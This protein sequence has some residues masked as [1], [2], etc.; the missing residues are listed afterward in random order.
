LIRGLEI[1]HESRAR[2]IEIR[3]DSELVLRQVT[4]EYKCVTESLVMYHTMANALLR[5]FT[6]VEIRH[7]PR[8]ENQEANDLAQMASGYKIPKDQTQEP[9]E[10]KNKRSSN[11]AFPKKLLKP[12]LGG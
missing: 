5:S 6:H 1:A 4:K 3:G 8:I 9:I 7:L 12:K 10:I 11:D 2:F